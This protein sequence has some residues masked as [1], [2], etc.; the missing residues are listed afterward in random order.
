M[1]HRGH[2]PSDEGFFMKRHRRLLFIL[3][4]MTILARTSWGQARAPH[5]VISD[6]SQDISD[7]LV[8]LRAPE[9]DQ[10][11]P[12]ARALSILN[13]RSL[14]WERNLKSWGYSADTL[15][16]YGRLVNPSDQPVKR[17]MALPFSSPTVTDFFVF[18]ATGHLLK[19]VEAG[20]F[21]PL[22]T[23]ELKLNVTGIRLDI[24]ARSQVQVLIR[25]HSNSLLDTHYSLRLLSEHQSY[26]W[27]YLAAYGLYF[28]LALA[29]FFHNLSLY[30]SLRDT[31]YLSYLF[32]VLCLSSAI[33]FSSAFYS[34]FWYQLPESWHHVPY[35]TPALANIGAALFY[36]HFLQLDFRTSWLARSFLVIMMVSLVIILGTLA[37]PH[38]FMP[39]NPFLNTAT[40]LLGL[41]GCIVRVREKERYAWFLLIALLLPILSVC[42]YY[43]GNFLLKITVPSDIMS[44][45]FG[46]EMILISAGL[47]HRIYVRNQRQYQ[48]ESQQ[49]AIIHESKMRALGEMAS[50]M[51]H[52]INNPLMIISGFALVIDR[53][54]DRQPLDMPRIRDATRKI[55]ASVDR[56]AFIVNSLRSFARADSN[57]ALERVSM[58]EI[59]KQALVLH[60]TQIESQGIQLKL[61]ITAESALVYGV[62]SQLIQVVSALLDNAITALKDVPH[63]LLTVD[64]NSKFGGPKGQVIL[65]IEDSG[66]GIPRELQSKIFQPFFTTRT[67]G[68]GTGL[69]LSRAQGIV[70][71][72]NGHLYFESRPAST[73]FIMELPLLDA[74]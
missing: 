23:R 20:T 25:Q 12:D 38:V 73:C 42:S 61:Q 19:K 57:L 48:W 50:G 64:L 11:A 49:E 16:L 6:Q 22:E 5:V 66:P 69:G 35:A 32:F 43:V 51:A 58:D 10:N 39:W 29:L 47:S 67:V 52:E 14:P 59:I 33:L 71:S 1:I 30:F 62:K 13:D 36:G 9:E 70:R 54:I 26:E 31:F 24:P 17:V 40:V 60:Q 21:A 44:V 8:V 37:L 56:I 2:H 72:F 65:K 55:E 53:L 3:I 4:C 27:I 28:G 15:W 68:K 46:L 18:D 34:L 45:A 74:A 63:K 7:A 41:W